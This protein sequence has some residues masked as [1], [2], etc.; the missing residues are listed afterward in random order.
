VVRVGGA[1]VDL[2]VYARALDIVA[3]Q[4]EPGVP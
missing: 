3:E 2:P 1:M 4:F